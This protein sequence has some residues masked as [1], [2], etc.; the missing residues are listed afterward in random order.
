MCTNHALA[1]PAPLGWLSIGVHPP[2]PKHKNK[3]RKLAY[4]PF[5]QNDGGSGQDSQVEASSSTSPCPQVFPFRYGPP[6]HLCSLCQVTL[7]DHISW[8]KHVTNHSLPLI[9]TCSKCST[10]C[11]SIYSAAGHFWNC[12][13]GPN[14]HQ[15]SADDLPYTCTSCHRSFSTNTGL[16][17]LLKRSH[18][19]E[20]NDRIV[21]TRIKAR[22]SNEETRLL[23]LAEA[24]LPPNTSSINEALSIQ[25]PERSIEA[26]K[27]KQSA[28]KDLLQ[29]F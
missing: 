14:T 13:G 21:T 3:P 27:G 23:A 7:F 20:F 28:Y 11:A 25:F 6:E 22:W 2:A 15:P 26:I 24:S 19:V 18:P 10:E 29:S 8:E 1:P 17:L 4:E 5:S 16:S 9:Y 12:S